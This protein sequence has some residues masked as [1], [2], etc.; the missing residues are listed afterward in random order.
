MKSKDCCGSRKEAVSAEQENGCCGNES[1][2]K[3]PFFNV[4][5]EKV[6]GNCKAGEDWSADAIEKSKIPVLSCEGPCVKGEIAR[7]A[8][9]LL[10]GRDDRFK[11]ACHGET[12]YVP[13]SSMAKWVKE[14]SAAVM[15]DGCFLACHGRI[16]ENMLEPSRI[17][18]INAH[19]IHKKH[20]DDFAIEEV[21]DTELNQ[22]AMQVVENIRAKI[23]R[24]SHEHMHV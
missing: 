13:H 8:A 5:V 19:S 15:I 12:F 3:S 24:E 22:L 4:V 7:R 2:S 17:L 23:P 21:S 1:E 11:R 6:S 10:S 9:G 20:G 14:S 16:L 18:H